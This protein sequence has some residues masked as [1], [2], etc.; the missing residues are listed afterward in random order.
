MALAVVPGG[1]AVDKIRDVLGKSGK[2]GQDVAKGVTPAK[3]ASNQTVLGSYP[4]YVRVSDNLGARRFEI[5]T[6]VWSRMSPAERWGANQRFLDRMIRRGDEVI[7]SNSAHQAQP[8]TSF[9]RE[10]QY[11]R[12][13]GYRVSDD[14]MRMLPPGN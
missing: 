14:G 10:V 6:E 12:S 3:R 1:K 13:Q 4:D 11:L 5:P 7:L 9:Y 2:V 8:G